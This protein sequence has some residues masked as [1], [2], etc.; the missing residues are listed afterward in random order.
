MAPSPIKLD[1]YWFV[2]NKMFE[3]PDDALFANDDIIFIN[4]GSNKRTF[5]G[6]EIDIIS[7]GI[8]KNNVVDVF[9]EDG[10]EIIIPARLLPW[11]NKFK[12]RETIKEDI[13]ER[14][15]PVAWHHAS[16][17]RCMSED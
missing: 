16:W 3:K 8:D 2:T 1:I 5:P 10:P 14:L 13:S 4:E 12:K 11:R 6:C 7:V 17:D 9:Y 15:M